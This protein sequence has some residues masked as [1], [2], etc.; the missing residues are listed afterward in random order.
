M[1][2]ITLFEYIIF[3]IYVVVTPVVN[4]FVFIYVVHT[5]GT[6]NAYWY[7]FLSSSIFLY[8]CMTLAKIKR[9][10]IESAQN[11]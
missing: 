5:Y 7:L 3:I 9:K 6:I 11:Q 2:N 10:Q 1:N 4:M 8:G